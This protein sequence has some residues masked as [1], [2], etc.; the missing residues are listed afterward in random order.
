MNAPVTIKGWCPTALR[1]MMSGD[2]LLVRVRVKDATLTPA[3]ARALADASHRFGNG[4]IDLTSRA[5]LQ[6]RGVRENTFAPLIDALRADG[7]VDGDADASVNIVTSPLA[8]VDPTMA[9]DPRPRAAALD[10]GMRADAALRTLPGKFG[11]AVDGGGV[12]PLGEV[13]ADVAVGGGA[14]FLHGG[15]LI[16]IAGS[17]AIALVALDDAPA[18]ALRL[19]RAFI[20]LR[21]DERR[22]R[23][24]VARIGAE[25]VFAQ[26][27]LTIDVRASSP[28]NDRALP[29]GSFA[30]GATIAVGVAAP[31]GAWPADDFAAVAKQAALL[32]KGSLRVT[33]WR[34]L[35]VTGF[36]VEAAK[37]AV[38]HFTDRELIVSSDDPRLAVAACAG[39]PGCSAASVDTRR[40]ATQLA[41]ALPS[42][43]GVALHVSGCA[44]GCAHPSRT[45]MSLVGNDGRYDL[46]VD[47]NASDVPS[48]SLMDA[49]TASR[50]VRERLT[51]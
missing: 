36:T 45:A 13:G 25:A 6:L 47:G 22:M 19:A 38:R 2:G 15:G 49:L 32:P 51:S 48:R 14:P 43:R 8:G 30:F 4:Q 17:S 3:A 27:G 10:G 1:P 41:R 5:N 20:H 46:V 33:P 26:A 42:T 24:L 34:V 7:L 28:A 35:L 44:K 40:L 29:L 50:A 31:F 11:F 12:L 23:A 16:R 39:A 9:F 18:A 37:D 21:R